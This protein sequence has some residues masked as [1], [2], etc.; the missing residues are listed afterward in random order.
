LRRVSHH[1][2]GHEGKQLCLPYRPGRG[3]S[4]SDLHRTLSLRP[5]SHV[6][7]RDSHVR[8]HAA[9]VGLLVGAAGFP[10]RHPVPRPPPPQRAKTA[11]PRP[12]WLFRLLPPHPLPPPP[13]PLI[14]PTS[15]ECGG[16]TLSPRRSFGP[17][18]RSCSLALRA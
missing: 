16:S 9:G 17:P 14:R 7:R 12:P 11:P 18:W 13:P 1:P 4:P 10:P 5:A 8:F 6:F 15:L 3:G 2:L